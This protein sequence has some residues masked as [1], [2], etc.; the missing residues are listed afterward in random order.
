M[1]YHLKMMRLEQDT[2]K[3]LFDQPVENDMKTYDSIQKIATRQ[4]DYYTTGRLLDYLYFKEYY[5]V[6]AIDLSE[7]Q[8]LD[9]NPKAIQQ[10]NFTENLERDRNTTVSL[11]LEDVKENI[12]NFSQGSVSIVNLFC[13]NIISI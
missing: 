4:G 5:K 2:K 8:E 10:I 3:S 11:I 9:T 13:F 6:I 1:L 12:S 7:K